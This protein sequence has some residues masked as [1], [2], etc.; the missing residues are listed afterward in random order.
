MQ[1][2]LFGRAKSAVGAALIGLGV[3]VLHENL[4]HAA[5]Q[6]S[7]LL[8]ASAKVFGIRHRSSWRPCEYCRPMALTTSVL[9]RASFSTR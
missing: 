1:H 8:D 2:T 7:R 9:C 5:S 3:F 4:G 6:L